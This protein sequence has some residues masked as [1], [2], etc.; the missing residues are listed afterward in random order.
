MALL[1]MQVRIGL[2]LRR[3][4]RLSGIVGGIDDIAKKTLHMLLVA[5]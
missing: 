5:S 4:G 1:F 2:V 3:N